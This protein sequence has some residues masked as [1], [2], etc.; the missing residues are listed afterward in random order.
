MV[1]K[2]VTK[3]L[4]I[5]GDIQ[6]K[7]YT[8]RGIKV[9]L[10]SDLAD[11]F[12]VPTKRIN[13]QRSRNAVKFPEDFAFQLTDK[14][15]KKAV[16]KCDRL[17]YSATSPWVYTRSGANQLTTVLKSKVATERS[18]WI[19]RA[20]SEL[21]E[22][23]LILPEGSGL[24]ALELYSKQLQQ[25]ANAIFALVK[26][27][28]KAED[29]RKELRAN[30][31]LIENE[32]HKTQH[33]VSEID[34]EAALSR[35]HQLGTITGLLL[36]GDR[37]HFMKVWGGYRGKWGFR[38]KDT[39]ADK[40]VEAENDFV[41]QIISLIDKFPERAQNLEVHHISRLASYDINVD[42]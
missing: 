4:V 42:I 24:D 26:N 12:E 11:L 18:I 32:V 39:P 30:M 23:G 34:R 21:E 1:K 28:Q 22:Q 9:M 2:S 8:V 40:I 25:Q 19:M 36:G 41:L 29:E 35:I 20:F 17:K 31:S 14:E 27:A 38:Y 13:E 33:I 16:A 10:A 37:R 15:F 7:I 5:I 6:K 3:D